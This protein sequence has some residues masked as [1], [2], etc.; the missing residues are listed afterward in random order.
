MENS[1]RVDKQT[2]IEVMGLATMRALG[3][4]ELRDLGGPRVVRQHSAPVAVLI[5]YQQYLELQAADAVT[6]ATL[7]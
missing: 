6:E 1:G 3:A 5:P 4:D 2:G 7:P